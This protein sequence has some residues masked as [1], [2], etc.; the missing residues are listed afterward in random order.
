MEKAVWWMWKLALTSEYSGM[1]EQG[2]IHQATKELKGWFLTC[3]LLHT[4]VTGFYSATLILNID[5]ELVSNPDHYTRSHYWILLCNIS[6]LSN[7]VDEN[8]KVVI[9]PDTEDKV[10]IV[11]MWE[12]VVDHTFMF[13]IW[14]SLRQ[15]TCMAA[16]CM[17][18]IPAR[19]FNMLAI[20]NLSLTSTEGQ[21]WDVVGSLFH[22]TFIQPF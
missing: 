1:R 20:P 6:K 7:G 16:S 4:L 18:P 10:M 9:I 13:V 14:A 17:A 21:T 8:H 15:G 2:T 11:T 3:F 19:V 12:L 22:G 5:P